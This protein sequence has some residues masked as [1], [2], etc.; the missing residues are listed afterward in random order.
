MT[1]QKT[2]M[3]S[4]FFGQNNRKRDT[5]LF[6]GTVPLFASLTKRELATVHA[7]AHHRIYQEDEFIFRKGQPGAA[8]FVVKSGMVN[9]VDHDRDNQANILST[10]D[11]NSFFG[12]LALLDD[13]PRSA[14]AVAAR[15]TE[16]FAFFRTDLERLLNSFP[17]IGHKVYRALAM[18]IGKRLKETN[19]QLLNK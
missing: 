1:P 19:E 3:W 14:S 2:T 18:I 11:D 8:M 13:S 7:I 6:L 10:L 16:T 12:E 17:Q 15:S 5:L 9:I 4:S